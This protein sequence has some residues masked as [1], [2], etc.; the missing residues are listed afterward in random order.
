MC[1]FALFLCFPQ[2][3]KRQDKSW[4]VKTSHPGEFWGLNRQSPDQCQRHRLKEAKVD[5]CQK[6]IF[7]FFISTENNV[8][9]NDNLSVEA[10]YLQ[11][12]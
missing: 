4:T 2:N 9:T 6:S 10:S 12:L 11:I 8:K 1:A 5:R 3:F 7:L